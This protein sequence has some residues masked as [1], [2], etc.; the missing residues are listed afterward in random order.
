MQFVY[1][2][3]T[4]NDF[5]NVS[6]K[7]ISMDDILLAPF[8]SLLWIAKKLQDSAQEE[9][10]NEKEAITQQLSEL[11]MMLDTEQITQEEF[12]AQ[13]EKLLDRLE[14]LENEFSDD[15]DDE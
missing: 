5:L 4:D 3:F 9:F 12:D 14:V 11:Y 6:I 2:Q 8:K 1:K 10:A 15:N 13:E 7:E